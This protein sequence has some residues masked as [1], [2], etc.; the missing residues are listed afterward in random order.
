[1]RIICTGEGMNISLDMS[2]SRLEE[3]DLRI[4]SIASH[5]WVS[6]VQ[7]QS[8]VLGL[9]NLGESHLEACSISMTRT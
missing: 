7:E 5:A 8:N 6:R 3:L 9:S 4:T 2:R 1:M